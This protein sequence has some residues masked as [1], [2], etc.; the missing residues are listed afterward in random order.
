MKCVGPVL[1]VLFI[2]T[3]IVFPHLKAKHAEHDRF[4]T[5]L[6]KS[7]NEGKHLFL[8]FTGSD[9]CDWCVK[10]EHEIYNRP[11]FKEYAASN[12]VLMNVDLPVN[13]TGKSLKHQKQNSL[14]A[15]RFGVQGFP[16]I[17][18][19]NPTGQVVGKTGYRGGGSAVYVEHIKR[20]IDNAK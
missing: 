4:A 16:T 12:L 3:V 7:E 6:L 14:L 11:A 5:A 2:A 18:I 1:G 20:I 13:K 15:Q 19:L 10:F 8:A 9:W 17:Y